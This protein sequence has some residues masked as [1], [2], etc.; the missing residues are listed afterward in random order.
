MAT[1]VEP[2]GTSSLFASAA[3]LS[4]CAG[5]CSTATSVLSSRPMSFTSFTTRLSLKITSN[6]APGS[7]SRTFSMTWLFVT[8]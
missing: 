7:V 6:D 2:T 8:T 1:T 5:T 4:P 3:A